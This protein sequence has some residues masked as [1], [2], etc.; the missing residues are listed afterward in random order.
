MA[1]TL[2][3]LRLKIL[4]TVHCKKI[5]AV[6]ERYVPMSFPLLIKHK[7]IHSGEYRFWLLMFSQNLANSQIPGG[8]NFDLTIK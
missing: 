2:D 3:L 1:Q 5:Y 6:E 8:R 7:K 4:T